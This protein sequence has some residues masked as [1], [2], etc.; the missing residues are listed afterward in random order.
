MKYYVD[1]LGFLWRGP[2]VSF[3]GMSFQRFEG[4]MPLSG[5]EKWTH[6]LLDPKC[7]M[8]QITKAKMQK[9]V[10]LYAVDWQERRA[11]KK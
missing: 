10:E 2:T 4:L 6:H 3:N 11:R 5:M 1:D 8:Q 9:I 7:E